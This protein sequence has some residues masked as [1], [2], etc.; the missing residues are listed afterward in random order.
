MANTLFRLKWLCGIACIFVLSAGCAH[1]WMRWSVPD[2]ELVQRSDAIVI[3]HVEDSFTPLEIS[4]G[5]LDSITSKDSHLWEYRTTLIVTKTLTGKI[6]IGPMPLLIH[7][8]IKPVILD[9]SSTKPSSFDWMHPTVAD[10]MT[11]GDT[12][13]GIYDFLGTIGGVLASSDI[14]R[15][16]LWFLRTTARSFGSGKEIT[17]APGIWDPQDVRPLIDKPYYE[18]VLTSD[19]AALAPFT[20]GA[21]WRSEQARLAQSRLKVNKIVQNPDLSVR[22]DQLMPIFL[23]KEP[24]RELAFAAI[25]ATG[26]VGAAKL[27]PV[28]QTANA[29]DKG[30]IM[31]GWW[32]AKYRES[33]PLVTDFLREQNRWWSFKS[34]EDRIFASREGPRGGDPYHDAR[35]ISF[36]NLFCAIVVLDDFHATEAK[37]IV[38]QTRHQWQDAKPFLSNNDLLQTCDDALT[39]L[40]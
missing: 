14:R 7:Y 1:A 18:A 34:K 27:V 36:R 32:N 4:K 37:D 30:T 20:V 24:A 21:S 6:A 22:C 12:P 5:S 15:D 2:D 25:I 26:S 35:S 29:E 11:F 13:V 28:F 10:Q 17:D 8:G 38:A 19:P 33:V 39:D 3:G 31:G 16:H 9:K 40:K 23:N